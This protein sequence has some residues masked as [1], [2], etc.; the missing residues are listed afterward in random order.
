MQVNQTFEDENRA[1]WHNR[2][3]GYAKVNQDELSSMQHD[4]WRDVL[5]G[6]IHRGDDGVD[7]KDLHVLD[8]GTGPG[9]FSI[10]LAEQ[11]YRVSAVD[12]TEAML[13]QA[14]NNAGDLVGQITFYQM[15]AEELHFD[16]N[17]FD[18][19]VTRNLT[20]NLPHPQKAYREWLRVLKK[21]GILLNF[22]ANWY[23]YL[24]DD[25]A[26]Q[27]HL[28]DRQN[29]KSCQVADETEGTDIAAMESIAQKVP[30]S[31]LQRPQ[32]DE[33]VITALGGNVRVDTD[34]WKTVWTHDE[35]INNS[36]TPMFLIE[37]RKR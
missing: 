14:K 11:G 10:L 32:W 29:I 18:A 15:N 1:Y 30:L 12:Y 33:K 24:Y 28:K 25:T 17:S 35:Y 21:G 34:I 4:V 37:V 23:R 8:I 6:H 20:W 31:S 9:F 7:K 16:D 27:G 13:E 3:S 26:L 5:C 19:I 2:S 36:S 22:D